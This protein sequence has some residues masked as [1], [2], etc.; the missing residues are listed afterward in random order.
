MVW[1]LKGLSFKMKQKLWTLA[2]VLA[3]PK[4]LLDFFHSGMDRGGIQGQPFML[5]NHLTMPQSPGCGSLEGIPQD[6]VEEPDFHQ[7]HSDP[8]QLG[9]MNKKTYLCSQFY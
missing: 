3:L 7:Q 9:K 2:F 1:A 5:I 8:P 6:P 4:T